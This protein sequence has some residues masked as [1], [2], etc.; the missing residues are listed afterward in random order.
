MPSFEE[1]HRGS[2]RQKGIFSKEVFSYDPEKET[3]ICPAGETLRRRNYNKKR[4]HYEYRASVKTCARCKLRGKCTQAK[5]GRSLKRHIRQDELDI[6]L[7]EAKSKGT[8]RD[9]KHR[10]DLS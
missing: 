7:K 4:R 8:K 5:D 6:M 2:G 9:I 3:F 10:Q 1:I